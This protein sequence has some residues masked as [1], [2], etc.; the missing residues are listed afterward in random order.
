MV[1]YLDV[2]AELHATLR[3]RS[4]LEIGVHQG[5]SL[6]LALPGTLAV[7]V[8]PEPQP[9]AAGEGRRHTEICTSDEFFATGRPLGVFGDRPV[10]LVFIDGLHLFEYALRDFAHA[11]ALTGPGSVIALHDCLPLDAETSARERTTDVWTGDVWKLVLCLLDRRPDLDLTIIDAPPSGLLLARALNAN[12]GS[13]LADYES[14]VEEYG[15]LEFADWL[16]RRDEVLERT[17]GSAESRLWLARRREADERRA[18]LAELKDDLRLQREECARLEA[19]LALLTGQLAASAAEADGQRQRAEALEEDLAEAAVHTRAARDEA[20]LLREL[21]A[22]N[23]RE[24]ASLAARLDTVAA[25]T[26]WRVTAPLRRAGR[27]L[28]RSDDDPR[29]RSGT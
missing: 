14:V 15:A 28:R 11:E 13:L 2:L 25:S 6:R 24:A 17:T 10:D 7:G 16:A 18:L 5:A 8:D 27:L 21:L 9:E 1:D 4:Y 12:D 22:A 23:E 20:G 29:P 26:S 19:R 3:P